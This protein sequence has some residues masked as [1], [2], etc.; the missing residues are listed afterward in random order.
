[1][2]DCVDLSE[3]VDRLILLIE[4]HPDEVGVRAAFIRRESANIWEILRGK[5]HSM[6]GYL[7]RV[8]VLD[9]ELKSRIDQLHGWLSDLGDGS[10]GHNLSDYFNSQA[11]EI[12]RRIDS[13]LTRPQAGGLEN[14]AYNDRITSLNFLLSDSAPH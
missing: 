9:A 10:T 8:R 14:D 4:G 7:Q 1:M 11:G 2:D 3:S 6:A 5:L 13:I 12:A